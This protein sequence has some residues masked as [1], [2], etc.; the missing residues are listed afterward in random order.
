M[1]WH[2]SR[3][4]GCATGKGNV[5]RFFNSSCR[6]NLKL[7]FALTAAGP[8]G[9]EFV[10]VRKVMQGEELTWTY[11]AAAGGSKAAAAAAAADGNRNGRG[12]GSR[13][14]RSSDVAKE[15]AVC[16]CGAEGCSGR[17]FV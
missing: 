2:F 9:L 7:K 10:A 5:S 13:G 14:R 6:P 8:L 15:E 3:H 16:L 4:D 17:M 11:H 1:T 12:G